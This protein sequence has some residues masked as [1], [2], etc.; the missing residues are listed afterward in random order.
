VIAYIQLDYQS[1][2][3][4]EHVL[5]TGHLKNQDEQQRYCST[6]ALEEVA[7]PLLSCEL[8]LDVKAIK[9]IIAKKLVMN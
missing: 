9:R 8:T 4:D 5:A 1:N 3:I 7:V 6:D 2:F